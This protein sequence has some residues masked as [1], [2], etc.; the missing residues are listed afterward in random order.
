M[1]QKD[2]TSKESK[3]RRQYDDAFK[4]DALRLIKSGRSVSEIS[5][6]LGISE[7]LLY[8]WNSKSR[9]KI[10]RESPIDQAALFSENELLRK[11]LRIAEMERDILKKAL[12]VFSQ[13]K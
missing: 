3:R 13:S 8:N 6:S 5:K 9:L 1:K 12:A 10:L 2:L 7:Q 4:V 11:Q